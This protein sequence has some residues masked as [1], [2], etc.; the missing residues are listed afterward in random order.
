MS[1]GNYLEQKL[2]ELAFGA[3]SFTPAATL[4]VH[5]YTAAPSDSGGG[6]EV[7]TGVWTNYSAASVTNNDTNWDG[8]EDNSQVPN[9]A[10][11]SFGTAT[12]SGTPPVVTHFAIKDGSANLYGWGALSSSKTVY[13][14]SVVKFAAGALTV[15]MD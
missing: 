9:K 1:F 14:G 10:E 6:T 5:L 12:I 15:S 7:S 2:L 11:I 3:R 8:Y 4:Y 13:D